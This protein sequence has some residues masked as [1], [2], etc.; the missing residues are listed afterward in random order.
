MGM[1]LNICR[2]I[3]EAHGSRPV[4]L[5][6]KKEGAA[7]EILLPLASNNEGEIEP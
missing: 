3:A 6:D 5:D 1:R 7:F 2:S 4:L